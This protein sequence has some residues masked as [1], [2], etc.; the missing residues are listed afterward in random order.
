MSETFKE[1]ENEK[2]NKHN[3][4]YGIWVKHIGA[5]GTIIIFL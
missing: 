4:N 5:H 1:S 2:A 3:V